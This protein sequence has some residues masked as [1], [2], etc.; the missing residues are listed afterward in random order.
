[1]FLYF[2]IFIFYLFFDGWLY[3]WVTFGYEGKSQHFDLHLFSDMIWYLKNGRPVF[4][5][6]NN[7]HNLVYI[8]YWTG[9]ISY[10]SLIFDNPWLRQ[11]AIAT[12]AFPVVSL[13]STINPLVASNIFTMQVFHYHS[14]ILQLVYDLIH[15]SG[16][17]LGVYIYKIE[18]DHGNNIKLKYMTPTI[19]F[20]W[21][22]FFLSRVFLQK[23]PFFDPG[24]RQGMIST[25]QINNMPFFL[26]GF[27]YCIVV[28]ILYGVN[29]GLRMFNNRC[30]N[31]SLKLVLPFLVFAGLTVIMVLTG[32]IVLQE[33]PGS[34][35]LQ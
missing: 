23:W 21:L 35:F 14:Y 3:E 16:T 2:G 27:E 13:L 30:E 24:N 20:S 8:C 32:L 31:R 33:I 1:M 19:L 15:I 12:M 9:T 28:F 17:I 7:Q 10:L 4:L 5:S 34:S 11:G 22:L 25:N 6:T 18:L 26:Y 29:T